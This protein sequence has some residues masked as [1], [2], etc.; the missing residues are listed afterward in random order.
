VGEAER[1]IG[2]G[3]TGGAQRLLSAMA[4]GAS[5]DRALLLLWRR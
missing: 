2:Q 5:D 1:L 4:S 3:F